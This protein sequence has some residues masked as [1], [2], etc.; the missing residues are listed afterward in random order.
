MIFT[1]GTLKRLLFCFYL[2]SYHRFLVCFQEIY[3][4]TLEQLVTAGDGQASYYPH[5]VTYCAMGYT[6]LEDFLDCLDCELLENI[7]A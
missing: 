4:S 2:P 7:L 6:F 1:I 3:F 5:G